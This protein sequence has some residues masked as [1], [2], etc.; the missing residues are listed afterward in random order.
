MQQP[1]MNALT[2]NRRFVLRTEKSVFKFVVDRDTTDKK[3]NLIARYKEQNIPV[4]WMS[5]TGLIA[6][7]HLANSFLSCC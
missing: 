3:T 5:D 7:V 6:K 1:W 4:G 2:A